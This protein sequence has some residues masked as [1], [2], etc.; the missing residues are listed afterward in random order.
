MPAILRSVDRVYSF[1][2]A[3]GVGEQSETRWGDR[4]GEGTLAGKRAM[5]LVTT[6]G[7]RSTTH[8]VASM[9]RSRI[10]S[11]PLTTASCIIRVT[12]CCRLSSFTALIDLMRQALHL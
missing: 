5:L 1:G 4:Y 3:Y 7:W 6:G 10:Y 12:T 8:L 11:F 2:F 9:V